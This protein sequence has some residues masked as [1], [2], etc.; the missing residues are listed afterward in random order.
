MKLKRRVVA[1]KYA[2]IIEA[3]YAEAA[4]SDSMMASDPL[5]AATST[6][7]QARL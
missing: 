1:E 6:A 2:P 4:A 7:L 3:M 5:A